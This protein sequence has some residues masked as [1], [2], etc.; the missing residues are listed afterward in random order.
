MRQCDTCFLKDKCPG[1]QAGANCVYNIPVQIRT[2]DQMRG[3]YDALIEIQSQRVLFMKM[4]EDMEGG[5]ADP[6]LTTEIKLLQNLID[7][8]HEMDQEGFSLQIT[9]KSAGSAGV[10]SRLF[11]REAGERARELPTA[12]ASSDVMADIV[13]AE[14][15]P[16][17]P[18]GSNSA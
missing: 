4:A 5:Y 2:K 17:L 16:P 10:L 14:T 15:L 1:F 7:K 8:R 11:G 12:V 18:P 13:D 9:A 3:L 6:N